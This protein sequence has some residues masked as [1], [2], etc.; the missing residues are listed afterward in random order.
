M[1]IVKITMYISVYIGIAVGFFTVARSV[2]ASVPGRRTKAVAGWAALLSPLWPLYAVAALLVG[3]EEIMRFVWRNLK[4][5]FWPIAK[6]VVQFGDERAP[7]PVISKAAPVGPAHLARKSVA[8]TTSVDNGAGSSAS[9]EGRVADRTVPT[10][11][12]SANADA[13]VE[14]GAGTR[15]GGESAPS[16]P[17]SDDVE[18]VKLVDIFGDSARPLT[19]PPAPT[20]DDLQRG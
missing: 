17:V 20:E 15:D 7:E 5:Q 16:A 4:R 19:E 2:W 12:V 9:G 3:V 14:E 11:P 10:A 13:L 1:T 8:P 6:S 18:R